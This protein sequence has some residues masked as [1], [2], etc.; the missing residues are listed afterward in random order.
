VGHLVC[1]ARFF[2]LLI[3]FVTPAVGGL[4]YSIISST[5]FF[6]YYWS[7][8]DLRRRTFSFVFLL[9]FASGSLFVVLLCWVVGVIHIIHV[10]FRLLW[11]WSEDGLARI[12]PAGAYMRHDDNLEEKDLLL[13]GS[14]AWRPRSSSSLSFLWIFIQT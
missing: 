13:R 9:L 8:E 6:D 3:I 12:C 7:E 10:Q 4:N 11:S 5:F 2:F 1:P 14:F